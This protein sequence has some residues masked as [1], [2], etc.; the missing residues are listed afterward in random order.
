MG[1]G[2]ISVQGFR[3]A[4]VLSSAAAVLS[5]RAP[6]F[7]ASMSSG[8]ILTT[9]PR[10]TAPSAADL[11][12]KGPPG[13]RVVLGSKSFTRKLLLGELGVPFE[14]VPADIDEKAIRDPDPEVL[15]MKLAN[16]KA[17]ALAARP[18]FAPSEGGQNTLLLTS[19]QVVVFEGQIREKPESADEAREFIRGYGRSPCRTVGAIVVRSH[20]PFDT[21]LRALR[22]CRRG[23]LLQPAASVPS[24][25]RCAQATNLATG[26][27]CAASDTAS[28]HFAPIPEDVVDAI[29]AE[30]TCFQCAG[31]LMVEDPKVQPYLQKIEGGMDSVRTA[32]PSPTPGARFS[33]QSSQVMGLGKAVTLRLLDE[34]LAPS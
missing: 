5:A 26:K 30:G 25:V 12:W 20:S 6:A 27:R 31:G 8:K 21:A 4:A 29:V 16:A 10:Q 32:L 9:H 7:A 14:C 22:V 24:L 34:A 17:D 28:I 13:M 18:A 11:R 2:L 1:R 19:D 15:V 3:L 33:R 23:G